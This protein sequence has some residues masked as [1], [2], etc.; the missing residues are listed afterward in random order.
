MSLI[1]CSTS[2]AHLFYVI[3]GASNPDVLNSSRHTAILCRDDLGGQRH[4]E[5]GK[6][7]GEMHC[8]LLAG[9]AWS[10]VGEGQLSSV[11][12]WILLCFY[13]TTEIL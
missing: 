2:S 11:I 7:C 4:C 1:L 6:G 3:Q 5:K 8:W 9:M 12:P 10:N 13:A